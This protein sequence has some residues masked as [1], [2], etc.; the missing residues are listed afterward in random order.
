MNE[1]ARMKQDGMYRN[2]KTSKNRIACFTAPDQGD[3]QRNQE[4]EPEGERLRRELTDWL[5]IN[6]IS[7][8]LLDTDEHCVDIKIAKLPPRIKN[9]LSLWGA[10]YVKDEP[11]EFAVTFSE[12]EEVNKPTRKFRVAA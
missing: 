6:K 9:A 3:I 12:N 11:V 4:F 2:D 5:R 10:I 8:I 7:S 1:Y